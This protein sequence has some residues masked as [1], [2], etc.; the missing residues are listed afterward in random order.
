MP[1]TFKSGFNY[2]SFIIANLKPGDLIYAKTGKVYLIFEDYLQHNKL[3]AIDLIHFIPVHNNHT[4]I[5]DARKLTSS[6]VIELTQ[7]V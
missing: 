6:E 1:I 7:K 3:R 4:T 5:E 2:S